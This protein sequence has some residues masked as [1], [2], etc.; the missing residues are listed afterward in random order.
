MPVG[1]S[2]P[3]MATHNHLSALSSDTFLEV[4]AIDEQAEPPKRPRWFM[5]D[6]PAH[7][8]RIAQSPL[9]T[10]WV[11]ATNNLDAAMRLIQEAGIDPGEPVYLTRGSLNWRLL[12]KSDGS[13]ACGGVFPILIEWPEGINPVQQMQDQGIR[14]DALALS[15]P[16]SKRIQATLDALGIGTLATVTAGPAS[17][18]ARMHSGSCSFDLNQRPNLT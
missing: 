16:D 9:L 2:H 5:L 11:V 1:G 10:T 18:D 4:I 3:L 7:Q 8:T 14:L 17:L 13:L 12:L 15:H 6:D